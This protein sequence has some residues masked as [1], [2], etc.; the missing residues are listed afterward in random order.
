MRTPIPLTERPSGGGDIPPPWTPPTTQVPLESLGFYE[1]L[2]LFQQGIIGTRE[3]RQLL[4]ENNDKFASVRDSD[5]DREIAFLAEQ[6]AQM[7]EQGTPEPNAEQ[8]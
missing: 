1:W 8:A 2:E 6:R 3:F 4:H 7:M 5:I